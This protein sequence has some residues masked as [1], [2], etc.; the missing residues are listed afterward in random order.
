MK[1]DN[2]P[3]TQICLEQALSINWK[4]TTRDGEGVWEEAEGTAKREHQSAL[5]RNSAQAIKASRVFMCRFLLEKS[6][7]QSKE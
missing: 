5:G 4:Y 6:T 3:Q 7:I 1:L 2:S